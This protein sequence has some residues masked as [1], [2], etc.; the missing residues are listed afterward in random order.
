MIYRDVGG[1]LFKIAYRV[2]TRLHHGYHQAICFL[3]GGGWIIY[4]L[5]LYI[6]PL[7]RKTILHI[8]FQR[9]NFEL[10][11]TLFAGGELC[12]RAVLIAVCLYRALIFGS[13]F[14]TQFL[15]PALLIKYPPN[16]RYD[17]YSY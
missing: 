5:R 12:F 15:A 1:A 9:V 14:L 6:F 17:E 2:A 10:A 8:W 3:Y 11:H 7:L 16:R 13:K 4:K